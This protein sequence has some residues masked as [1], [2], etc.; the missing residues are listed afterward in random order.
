MAYHNYIRRIFATGFLDSTLNYVVKKHIFF[1][2]LLQISHT[3]NF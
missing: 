1:M 3:R 2:K